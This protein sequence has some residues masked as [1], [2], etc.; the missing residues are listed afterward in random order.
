M[1]MAVAAPLIGGGIAGLGSFFGGRSS[2]NATKNAAEMQQQQAQQMFARTKPAFDAS[3]NYYQGLLGND[4]NKLMQAVGP[5]ITNTNMLFGQAQRNLLGQSGARGGGLVAGQANLE[6]QRAA[7]LSNL[8][9]AAR[10]SAPAALG[11][12]A[13]GQQIQALQAL[14]GSQQSQYMQSLLQQQAY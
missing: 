5:D 12:L 6:G 8:V 4:P 3:F 9:G 13:S 7:T 10:A 11:N 14:A 1:P 2:G